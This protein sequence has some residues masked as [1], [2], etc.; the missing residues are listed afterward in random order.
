MAIQF[1]CTACGQPIEV[2]DDAGNQPVT[3]PYCRKVVTAP[4]A[5]DLNLHTRAQ[6]AT[7]APVLQSAPSAVQPGILAFGGAMPGRPMERS[8]MGWW[9]MGLIL[10]SIL[11]NVTVTVWAYSA[12]SAKGPINPK[13]MA[14][15]M[16]DLAADH[17][18]MIRVVQALSCGLPLAA[19][20]LAIATL[21]KKATPRWPAYVTLGLMAGIILLM[22]LS[23]AIQIAGAGGGGGGGT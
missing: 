10:A 18:V 14:K 19:L 1:L 21:V 4:A 5:T 8:A 3:C 17:P 13:D 11:L 12:L 6:T 2:D 23:V 16:Q 15:Q 9:S 7:P 22:C 20:V